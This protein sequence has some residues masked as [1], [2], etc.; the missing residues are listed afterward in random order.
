MTRR[1]LLSMLSVLPLILAY[2][3]VYFAFH[4]SLNILL[5]MGAMHLVQ[6][7][8]LLL[9]G[10]WRLYRPIARS[11]GDP[12]EVST[13]LEQ[14][15]RLPWNS[16][17]LAGGVGLL[18]V[19]ISLLPVVVVPELYAG[20]GAFEVDRIPTAFV[21]AA[22]PPAAYV[23]CIF[24]AFVTYFLIN[25]LVL[26][27]RARVYAEHGHF[28][29]PDRKRI[30]LTIV[31][32]LVV[33]AFIPLLL[34]ILELAVAA[35]TDYAQFTQMS[36][37]HTVIIDRFVILI[38]IVY[39]VVLV[40]RSFTKPIYCLL[41][42]IDKVKRGELSA[43][44]SV[45]TDDEIGTMT[46]EFN[47]MVKGLEERE[48]IRD[49]FGRYVTPDVVRAI[50]E[51]RIDV[52]GEVR[53]CTILVTDIASY[54]TL[55]EEVGPR[56]VVRLLNEYF[57]VLVAIIQHHRGVVNKFVGDSVFAIFNVPLDDPDPAANAIRAALEI[58]AVT[59]S[60]TFNGG[61]RLGTRIGINT[62]VVLAGNIGS[63]ERL[64]YTVIGDVVNVAARLE[65]LNRQY[66]TALLAGETTVNLAGESFPFVH[67]AEVQLRGMAAPSDVYAVGAQTA[68]P[69]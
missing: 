17:W 13:A 6:Y 16:T 7:G 23:F 46:R 56:K 61:R 9:L 25:D 1:Y 38:G 29:S 64:E 2:D 54:T 4:R 60:R 41:G 8:P 52:Q 30:A 15:R 36:P 68:V 35:G 40:T 66:G 10:S 20:A 19:A 33:L 62:G 59:A 53:T 57:S 44:A 67:V 50:L 47:E 31:S 12:R 26:D 3:L 45:I 69:R 49:T 63:T 55:A 34:V 48:F 5:A 39:A 32:V 27:L 37:M 11:L 58:Q 65:Q 43:R 42:E 21:L 18:T 22:V 28:S 24:P 14:V 51:R